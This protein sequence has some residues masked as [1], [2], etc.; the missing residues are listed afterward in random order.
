MNTP[1]EP[2]H[3]RI[4]EAELAVMD[5]LWERPRQTAAEVCEEVCTARG[6]SLATVKTLLARLVQKGRI[7][8]NG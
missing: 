7:W 8:G 2:V 1:G 5:V 4:T 3:E 6:W